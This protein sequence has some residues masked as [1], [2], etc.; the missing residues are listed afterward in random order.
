MAELHTS[1]YFKHPDSGIN[2]L[3]KDIFQSIND[4]SD[5]DPNL[6]EENIINIAES[7]NIDNGESLAKE[8]FDSVDSKE[9]LLAESRDIV[10]GYYTAYFVHG[11][12]GEEIIGNII[13]FLGNLCPE[14]DARACL[15]GDD[16]PWEIFYRWEAGK[17]KKEYFEP[18]YESIED[19]EFEFP[20]IY[21]WW[22]EGLPEEIKDG[23]L[24][25][26]ADE[27]E[28]EDEDW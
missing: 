22:H 10:S 13:S 18:D 6:I 11:S 8:L 26:W 7:V 9:D 1:V 5:Q 27:D 17:V 16:D 4:S 25:E 15:A 12:E 21:K 23:F 24:N 14:I 2:K 19:D 20:D 3:L 28:D